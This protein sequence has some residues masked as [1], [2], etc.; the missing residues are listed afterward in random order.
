MGEHEALQNKPF[1]SRYR[2]IAITIVCCFIVLFMVVVSAYATAQQAGEP[3]PAETATTMIARAEE[4]LRAV[5]KLSPMPAG[6][7]PDFAQAWPRATKRRF[8]DRNANRW[9]EAERNWTTTVLRHPTWGLPGT[10]KAWKVHLCGGEIELSVDAETGSVRSFHDNIL[11]SLL[12]SEPA[13]DI[14]RCILADVAVS[15]ATKYVQAAGINLDN[16]VLDSITFV[17][18]HTPADAESRKWEVTWRR[19]WQGVPFW[20]QPIVVALDAGYGRLLWF[21]AALSMQPPAMAR[22]DILPDEAAEIA[23]RFLALRS[24]I[25]VGTP[26]V[27]LQIVLPT[28]YWTSGESR[29]TK[30]NPNAR[31]AW[32]VQYSLQDPNDVPRWGEVWI[33][34][35]IGD[36]LGGNVW[37][38][39]GKAP[40]ATPGVETVR[41]LSFAKR[42]E[43]RPLIGDKEQVRA[44]DAKADPLK[45]YGA[46]SL[47]RLLR[48]EDKTAKCVPTHRL[49]AE[50]AGGKQ[51]AFEYDAKTGLIADSAGAVAQAGP[52]LMALLNP[53]GSGSP[54]NNHK[55]L[56]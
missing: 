32:I 50:V 11:T 51:A 49:T 54:T 46:L 35:A 52:L 7:H 27:A 56:D 10:G 48:P 21:G 18:N 34:A 28:D 36:V 5:E 14:S 33:D 3:A 19:V 40:D 12:G 39:L 13:P 20:A 16:F 38:I 15:R 43:L 4:F 25:T 24:R 45:F 30:R 47:L 31:L 9:E 37:G 23:K 26:T 2:H 1:H 53:T 29:V 44:L 17:D 55:S 41:A 6:T 8:Y 42:L 22:L